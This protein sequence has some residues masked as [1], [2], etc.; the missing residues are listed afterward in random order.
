M[1]GTTGASLIRMMNH[2]LGEET[3]KRGLT[4][5]LKVHKFRNAR[6]DDLW[7]QL[8]SQA[9]QDRSL[10][11]NMT[12]KK[13]MD[14]WTL[15]TGYPVVT[16][17]RN[18]MNGSANISQVSLC[19]GWVGAEWMGTWTNG[20]LASVSVI[21]WVNMTAVFWYVTLRCWI[22]G[23]WYFEGTW[24]PGTITFLWQTQNLQVFCSW[25]M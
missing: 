15:Q 9:H 6:Q 10:P 18:Y 16:V 22:S 12:V 1:F 5:Y 4:N 8:T 24:F 7:D 13:I 2:F 17:T 11:S 3:L 20:W 19:A 14:T 25:F 21:G 23:S